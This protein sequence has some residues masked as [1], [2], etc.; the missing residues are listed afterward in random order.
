MAFWR[1]F[2]DTPVNLAQPDNVEPP[3]HLEPANI[4]LQLPA[5]PKFQPDH[6]P[7][8]SVSSS[9]SLNF[10][11]LNTQAQKLLLNVVSFMEKERQ[12][13]GSFLPLHDTVGRAAAC[14]GL[15]KTTIRKYK[16]SGV[17][18]SP[19]KLHGRT[20]ICDKLDDFS[21]SIVRKVVYSFYRESNN[22]TLKDIATKIR[23]VLKDSGVDFNFSRETVR[24][25]IL[26]LGFKY[27]QANNRI[28]L[29]EK[30]KIVDWRLKYL[31]DIA[32][33]RKLNKPLIYLDETW[34]NT[35]DGQKK[36]WTDD[37]KHSTPKTPVSRGE[38]LIIIG[39]G[40]AM[41]WINNSFKV[42]RTRTVGSEDYHKDMNSDVF[43]EWFKHNLIPNIPSN[44]C[45]IMDNASYHSRKKNKCPT[46]GDKKAH[47][48][49]W[50]LDHGGE[51][52]TTENQT[53]KQL[54]TVAKS[55]NISTTFVIDELAKT[56]GH[57][58]IR[59]P[60]Y[61]CHYNP[62]ELAWSN[63][64]RKVRAHNKDFKSEAVRKIIYE[65]AESITVELWNKFCAH[66]MK[67]E[68][69]SKLPS[70]CPRIEPLVI[71]DEDV[72]NE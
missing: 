30:M 46:S 69:Q 70:S 31:S 42:Y 18:R 47:I 66:V 12:N 32:D 41:G 22:P 19:K 68:E 25:L 9:S 40:G 43:E 29:T 50:I 63:L 2:A 51:L 17:L 4:G 58:L 10:R 35:G 62:I 3:M 16:Q 39:A 38:R 45:I 5:V 59:L 54:L 33:E 72:A 15:S 52:S 55:M 26:R 20:R 28:H 1:P 34:F 60:P 21:M 49:Q 6:L 13:N 14:L 24:K 57:T 56:H 44:S 36:V 53:K 37:T 8:T 48:K 71:Y 61:H 65:S 11:Y 67:E 7:S 64:K 27:K 23:S